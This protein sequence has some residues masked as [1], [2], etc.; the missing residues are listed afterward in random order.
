[1]RRSKLFVALVFLWL[2]AGCATKG[3]WY[4]ATI[5]EASGAKKEERVT[6]RQ[7]ERRA[8]ALAHFGLGVMAQVGGDQT[9]ARREFEKSLQADPDHEALAVDLV[10]DYLRS[11]D[12]EKAFQLL[13]RSA[14]QPHA[15]GWTFGYL[16][17]L[18]RLK[19][20][21]KEAR[22]AFEEAIRRSP[23]IFLGYRGLADLLL[24]EGKKKEAIDLID[25]AL[26][27]GGQRPEFLGDFAVWIAGQVGAKIFPPEEAKR[28]VQQAYQKLRGQKVTNPVV[29]EAMG[30]A[31]RRVGLIQEAIESYER[32]LKEWNPQNPLAQVL[33]HEQLLRLYAAQNNTEGV[34][35]EA[36]ALQQLTPNNP[37]PYML[38]GTLA[39][40]ENQLSEAEK[41]FRQAL[42]LDPKL[43]S[44]Y[45]RLA[46]VL[47]SQ[48]KP[49]EALQVL[50]QARGLFPPSFQMEFYTGVCYLA[51][52]EYKQAL[53][54]LIS[55]QIHAQLT[56][57]NQLTAFFYFQLGVA[58]HQSGRWPA[59]ET[60]LK[61]SIQKDPN[62]APALNYLGYS[63]ADQGK[64]LEEAYQLIRRAVKQDPNNA[65]YLDS[66]GW[67]L[68][69][70]GRYEEALQYQL[71]A[72]QNAEDPDPVL[73]D[74]LGDIY[75]ALGK[76]Q[77]AIEAWKKALKLQPS[78]KIAQK[79]QAAQ[80]ESKSSSKKKASGQTPPARSHASQTN[81]S[82]ALHRSS[83]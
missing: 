10:R 11:G 65:A 44:A 30:D 16:G 54:H 82:S 64:H 21:I 15:T 13:R 43:E 7:L 71:K 72:V 68:Y 28:W 34:R 81:S 66:L 14:K 45:Y 32:L 8:E 76:K 2:I 80:Q 57:P 51:L 62:F 56:D 26:K 24:R 59:A 52:E 3:G 78:K 20:Q 1:M 39:F 9:T 41:Q 19:G 37:L 38:L 69:R 33:I 40:Q 50:Q 18:Y 17:L 12:L 83:Q 29:L 25:K 73:W 47:I 49:K 79:I 48:G 6:D 70:L 46:A 74:H 35:R 63:W 5:A 4:V 55:A 77:K 42:S 31:C 36:E 27:A 61:K 23:D 22:K 53:S 75:A 60:A 58:Y 67:V